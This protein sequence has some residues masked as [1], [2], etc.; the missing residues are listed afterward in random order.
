MKFGFNR[1]VVSEKQ[2]FEIVD[3][4]VYICTYIHTYI[5]TDDRAYLSYKLTTEPKG[6][7]ELITNVENGNNLCQ[8]PESFYT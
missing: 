8:Y 5:H 2:M 4:H 6:T 7:G 3:I 1:P